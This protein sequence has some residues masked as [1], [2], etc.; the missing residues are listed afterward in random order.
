MQL[1]QLLPRASWRRAVVVVAQGCCNSGTTP[2]RR[3]REHFAE[4]QGGGCHAARMARSFPGRQRGRHQIREVNLDDEE[5]R[6][7]ESVVAGP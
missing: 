5:K 2:R 4:V 7:L 1:A 3:P 6:L